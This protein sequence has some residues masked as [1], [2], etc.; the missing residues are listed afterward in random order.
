MRNLKTSPF[1]GRRTT[2]DACG[3][4]LPLK[5]ALIGGI[6]C[7]EKPEDLPLQGEEDHPQVVEGA[8]R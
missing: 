4:Q 7:F 6:S 5:G 8:I 2:S 1:R 3:H